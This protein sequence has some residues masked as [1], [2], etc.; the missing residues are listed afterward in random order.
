[1]GGNRALSA[2]VRL[3]AATNLDL[4][5]AVDQGRFRRDLF[6]R[7]SVVPIVVPPL[8]ERRDEVPLLAETVLADLARRAGK[9]NVTSG[10]GV[11]AALQR[12]A[13]PGNIRELRNALERALILSRGETIELGHL[14]AEIREGKATDLS[15]THSLE[16]VERDHIARALKE[17]DGNRTRA[18]ELLG[19]SRSTLKRRLAEMKKG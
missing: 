6:Y 8:R 14:P 15:P 5:L 17:T 3:I 18:A 9:P 4:K 12:H 1:M 11:M 7:L 19:I 2:D 10:R 13:W 16:N